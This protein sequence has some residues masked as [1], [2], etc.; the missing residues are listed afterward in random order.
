MSNQTIISPAT[1]NEEMMVEKKNTKLATDLSNADNAVELKVDYWL[2][3]N[4]M[5]F[6]HNFKHITVFKVLFISFF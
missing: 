5:S 6:K 4:K 2:A 3:A 1:E